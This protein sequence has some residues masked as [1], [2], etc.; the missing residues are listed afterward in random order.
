VVG[1]KIFQYGFIALV[2]AAVAA[3]VVAAVTKR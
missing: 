2:V 1:M 3:A